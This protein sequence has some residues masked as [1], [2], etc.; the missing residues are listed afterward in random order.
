MRT[1]LATGNIVFSSG[2]SEAR[3]RAA[4]E[5]AVAAHGLSNDVFLRKPAELRAVLAEN[6]FP[7]AAAARPNHMLVLFLNRPADGAAL[8]AHAGPENIRVSGRHVFIDYAE[9]VG[10]SKLTAAVLERRLGQKGTARNWNTVGR[11][12]AASAS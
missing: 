10:R 6:P 1:V 2:A 12:L 4:V 9:G 5:G 11:L 8:E 3:I 7:E